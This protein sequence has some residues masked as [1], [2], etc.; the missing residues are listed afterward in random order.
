MKLEPWPT[1]AERAMQGLVFWI[2]HRQALYP[3][4]PLGESALVAEA[5]NLI[6]AHLERGDVLLCERA[7]AKLLP[8]AAFAAPVVGTSMIRRSDRADLVVVSGL[9][10]RDADRANSLVAELRVVIEV[11]RAGAGTTQIN[12][13]LVRLAAVKRA[14][15]NVRALL[16]VVSESKRPD[17]FVDATGKAIL[18]PHAIP[19]ASAHFRVR[20]AFKA[21]RAFSSTASAHYACVIEVFDGLAAKPKQRRTSNR[22]SSPPSR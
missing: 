14:S 18:G 5:C 16:F 11:K 17:R 22:V 20:R 6:C 12:R 19:N 13:D 21:A 8:P 1:W 10:Q 4:W 7:Y 3:H 15:P 9:S 2:G